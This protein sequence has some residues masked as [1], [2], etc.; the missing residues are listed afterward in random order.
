MNLSALTNSLIGVVASLLV[1]ALLVQVIQEFHKFLLSVKGRVYTKVLTDMLGPWAGQLCRPEALPD[2]QPRGP[3]Q[4]R[5][6]KRGG[7][8]L[9]L[10]RPTLV[11]AL[12]RTAPPWVRRTLDRLRQEVEWSG[13]SPGGPSPGWTEFTTELKNVRKENVVSDNEVGTKRA[14][15]S[16]GLWTATEIFGFLEKWGAVDASASTPFNARALEL[17]FRRKFLSHVMDAERDYPQLMKNFEFTY[18]RWNVRHSF[19][20]AFI[21]AMIFNLPFSEMWLS[22]SRLSPAEA[23]AAAERAMALYEQSAGSGPAKPS[24][25]PNADAMRDELRKLLEELRPRAEAARARE[26]SGVEFIDERLPTWNDF[27]KRC[28]RLS[29]WF[30]CAVTAVLVSFGAPFWNDLADALLGVGR[31]RRSSASASSEGGHGDD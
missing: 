3:F 7:V 2:L 23:V 17:A 27:W 13:G 19:T 25:E 26:E 8:L 31:G 10:D 16:P 24:S 5:R 6:L 29:Y 22:A 18:R 4:F 21:V 1:F 15:H 30:G 11:S 28:Q 20:I 12:E 9:P 14:L